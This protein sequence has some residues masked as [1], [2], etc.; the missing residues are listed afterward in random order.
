MSFIKNYNNIYYSKADNNHVMTHFYD[1]CLDTLRM[2]TK[3]VTY[4]LQ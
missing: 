1:P 4:Y 3:H 2:Y